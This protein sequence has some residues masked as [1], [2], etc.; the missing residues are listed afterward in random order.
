VIRSDKSRR[1]SIRRAEVLRVWWVEWESCAN[2]TAVCIV[3][4]RSDAADAE[5]RPTGGVG[6]V[7][8]AGGVG[9]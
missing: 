1:N 9:L 2:G 7:G 4:V 3:T 8:D 6:R 5:K